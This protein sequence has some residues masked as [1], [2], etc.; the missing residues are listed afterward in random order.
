MQK[1]I[2]LVIALVVGL[3]VGHY[4]WKEA[5][6][7]VGVAL[8]CATNTTCL[9]SLELTGNL[10]TSTPSLQV[11]T[12][13]VNLVSSNTATS[14]IIVGCYQTYATSTATPVKVVLGNNTL[15]TTTYAN[16]TSVG[17]VY[18]AYGTCP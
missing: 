14:S 2:Y 11:D 16:L 17:G 3:G 10:D 5:N 15:A 8:N 4:V 1:Y 9:S 12:G 13:K 7:G 18:W 6:T